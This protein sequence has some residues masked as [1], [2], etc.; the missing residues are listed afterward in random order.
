ME[1]ELEDQLKV[2]DTNVQ[3]ML[4]SIEDFLKF[5]RIPEMNI[6]NLDINQVMEGVLQIFENKFNGFKF[7]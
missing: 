1:N 3:D 7:F 6:K 4:G 2:V 5:A